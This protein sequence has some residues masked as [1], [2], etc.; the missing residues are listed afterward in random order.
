V[1]LIRYK[2]EMAERMMAT[3]VEQPPKITESL[4]RFSTEFERAFGI[5]RP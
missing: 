2:P 5:T 3:L 1:E 4:R